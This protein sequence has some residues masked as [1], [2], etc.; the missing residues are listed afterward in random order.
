MNQQNKKLKK[1]ISLLLLTKNEQDNIKTR[2]NWL[3]KCPAINELIVVDDYST[4]TSINLL[5]KISSPKLKVKIYQRKLNNHFANQRIFALS[6]TTNNWILWLD[7]D[8][9]PNLDLIRF[10]NNFNYQQKTTF[11]FKRTDNFLHHQLKHGETAS[12]HFVRLFDK[13]YGLFE[14][15]IHEVWV[16]H[17][18]VTKTKLIIHHHSHQNISALLQKINFYTDIRAQELYKQKVKTNIIQIIFLPLAKLIHNYIIRLG[19]LD[20]TPGLI[21]ALSMSLHSFLVRAKLW[22][23]QQN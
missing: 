16:S 3:K 10:L 12:L 4:D 7:A 1:H 15:P 19:F 18:P 5:K 2:L 8:E 9:Q 22:Q 23:K 17:Q 20:S 6:K 14:R 11:A 21:L 13:R